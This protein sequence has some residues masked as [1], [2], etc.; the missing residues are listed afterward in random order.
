MKVVRGFIYGLYGIQVRWYGVQ[1]NP[2]WPW[3]V[4]LTSYENKWW[5]VLLVILRYADYFSAISMDQKVIVD[6]INNAF[7]FKNDVVKEPTK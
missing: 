2:H 5:V 4:G 6:E 7:K 3:C 1:I